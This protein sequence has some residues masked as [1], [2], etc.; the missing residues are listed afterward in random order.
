MNYTLSAPTL[1]L[2]SKER[3]SYSVAAL[4]RAVAERDQ[5]EV[6]RYRELSTATAKATGQ[7]EL[8][9]GF[10]MPADVLGAP[11]QR[12]MTTTSG[13]AGGYAVATE[14]AGY[15]AA[16][17]R[18]SL[19]GQ[20]QI[21]RLDDLRANVVIPSQTLQHETVW[22]AE[23]AEAA[24]SQGAFGNITM[25]PR[26]AISVVT[27]SR[28]LLVQLGAAGQRFIDRQLGVSVAEAIDTALLQGTGG[29]QPV[30]ILNTLNVDTRTGNAFD[31]AAGAAMLKTAEGYANDDSIAW[32]SG[33]DAAETLRKRVKTATYGN[34]FMVEGNTMLG[35][36]FFVSRSMPA[37]KLICAPWS[38]VLLGGW[39]APE[40]RIDAST[41]FES[42]AVR[43]GIF[44][45]VDTA[46]ERPQA[47]AIATAVS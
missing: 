7:P 28:Q 8:S 30:G 19:I 38:N 5:F 34:G 10:Y 6:G 42:G 35:R 44:S 24:P 43:V 31:M 16:L 27:V 33:I 36:P 9:T 4:I 14:I 39:G 37:A 45:M 21:T 20:L 18:A 2:T 23:G 41:Y 29:A 25:T 3:N 15:A 26:T 11:Q 13:P 40:I 17:N 22:A 1:G 12:T 32:V 46:V 47:I